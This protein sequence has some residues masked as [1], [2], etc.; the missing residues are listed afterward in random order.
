MPAPN[1]KKT[2]AQA[3]QSHGFGYAFYEPPTSAIEVGSAGYLDSSGVWTPMPNVTD[4]VVTKNKGL[5]AIPAEKIR[6]A[7]KDI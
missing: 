2:Y 6:S 1:L 4:A 3:L 7:K 5:A